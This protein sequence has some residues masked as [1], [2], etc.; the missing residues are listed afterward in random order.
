MFSCLFSTF[1]A[2]EG[3]AKIS[4]A[5]IAFTFTI[6]HIKKSIHRI[7]IRKLFCVSPSLA[8]KTFYW[9]DTQNFCVFHSFTNSKKFGYAKFWNFFN[10]CFKIFKKLTKLAKFFLK[11]LFNAVLLWYI[12]YLMVK[13]YLW[14]LKTVRKKIWAFLGIRKKK[15]FLGGGYAKIR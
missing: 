10:F 6:L 1:N 11:M 3:Y 15:F 13:R 7:F 5:R 4:A 9:S 2:P 8:W 14:C 12:M